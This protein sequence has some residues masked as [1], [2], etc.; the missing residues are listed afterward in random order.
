MVPRS[1]KQ[2]RWLTNAV[3]STA[4]LGSVTILLIP[5]F[6]ADVVPL[7][8][9]LSVFVIGTSLSLFCL[10]RARAALAK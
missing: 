3:R 9:L 4:I 7:W 2:A 8:A 1:N 10:L 5:L 6:F